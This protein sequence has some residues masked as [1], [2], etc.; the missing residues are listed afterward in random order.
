M[1]RKPLGWGDGDTTVGQIQPGLSF[2]ALELPRALV[3]PLGLKGPDAE[4][5]DHSRTP[6]LVASPTKWHL[7]TNQL[8]DSGCYKCRC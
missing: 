7:V 3:E 2:G 6:V 4:I 8:I 1:T 5:A